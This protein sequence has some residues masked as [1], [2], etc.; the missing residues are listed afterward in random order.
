MRSLDLVL[1]LLVVLALASTVSGQLEQLGESL[2]YTMLDVRNILYIV[3]GGIVAIVITLQGIKWSASAD[4]PGARKQ[5]K[6]GIVHAVVGLIIVILAA[7]IVLM[8][9][10]TSCVNALFS[11]VS[12]WIYGEPETVPDYMRGGSGGSGSG[13][14]GSGSGSLGSGFVASTGE[15]AEITNMSAAVIY[16]DPDT[17]LMIWL[18][19]AQGRE[20]KADGVLKYTTYDLNNLEASEE[21]KTRIWVADFKTVESGDGEKTTYAFV[22]IPCVRFRQYRMELTLA[23]DDGTFTWEGES[24]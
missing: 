13:S 1:V 21:G 17:K 11:P 12:Y 9:M 7:P 4:D 8:V 14:G 22:E 3:A 23:T 10:N 18:Y 6:E 20:L 2:C 19:D 5:A 15:G 24:G 16:C